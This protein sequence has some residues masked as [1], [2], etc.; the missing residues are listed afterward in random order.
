MTQGGGGMDSYVGIGKI[1]TARS[2][3]YPGRLLQVNLHFQ[4]FYMIYRPG[5]RS[6][7]KM[8]RRQFSSFL[9]FAKL[10]FDPLRHFLHRFW[11][12]FWE[13]SRNVNILD[14]FEESLSSPRKSICRVLHKVWKSFRMAEQV[15]HLLS[16]SRGG[17]A[18]ARVLFTVFQPE[19]AGGP[20]SRG[21]R[22]SVKLQTKKGRQGS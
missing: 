12:I 11:W 15:S 8:L 7:L 14:F 5:H 13:F 18:V 22:F 21:A 1:W 6:K 2:R 20:R 9:F 4:H 3:L 19:F 17:F 16:T 10:F